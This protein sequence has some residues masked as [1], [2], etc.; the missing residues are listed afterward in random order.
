MSVIRSQCSIH[1]ASVIGLYT[2]Y[3][4]PIFLRITSGRHKLVPGPFTLGWW[5]MPIGCVSVAWVSFIV[6]LLCFPSSQTTTADEMSM[7]HSYVLMHANSDMVLMRIQI[8]QSLLSWRSSFSRLRL[9]SFP[10]GNG[11]SVHFPTSKRGIRS[12]RLSLARRSRNLYVKI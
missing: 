9:G 2:S 5:Y 11:S 8:M 12:L 6:V 4:T 3:A 1:R 7:P 10:R